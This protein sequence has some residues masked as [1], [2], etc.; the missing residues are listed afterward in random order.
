MFIKFCDWG[1]DE[2]ADLDDNQMEQMTGT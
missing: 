2:I 1:L